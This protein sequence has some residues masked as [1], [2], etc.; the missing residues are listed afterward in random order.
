[1]HAA[2][3]MAQ[4]S[5]EV[6]V[7]LLVSGVL[8]GL[9]TLVG[10]HYRQKRTYS[11]ERSLLEKSHGREV[12]RM[13]LSTIHKLDIGHY[14]PIIQAARTFASERAVGKPKFSFLWLSIYLARINKFRDSVG[15]FYLKD[16]TA[17]SVLIYLSDLIESKVDFIDLEEKNVLIDEANLEESH[18]KFWKKL[19][20]RPLKEMFGKY[21]EWS[22]DNLDDLRKYVDCFWQLFITE[23]RLE[24]Y[25]PWRGEMISRL[26]ERNLEV[27]KEV[28]KNMAKD[29][30]V[31]AEQAKRYLDRL[32]TARPS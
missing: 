27:L 25:A 31:T 5:I 4:I 29:K 26:E 19:D 12:E 17:E 10:A 15:A 21:K 23:L 7:V 6:A 24:F 16:Q 20:K 22:K 13:I 14:H 2:V 18:A 30:L 1:M 9:I 32:K 3:L 28:L 8:G 11:G